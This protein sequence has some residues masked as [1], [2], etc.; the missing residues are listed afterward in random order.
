MT[1]PPVDFGMLG[2][3][4]VLGDFDALTPVVT[5]EQHNTF[6]SNIFSILELVK[7]PSSKSTRNYSNRGN[8]SDDDGTLWAPVL[9][10]SFPV[11][12]TASLGSGKIAASCVL[13]SAPHQ[14]YIGG[15]FRQSFTPKGNTST[16]TTGIPSSGLN[17]IGLY[18]STLKAF[19]PMGKGLDGP[20]RG[21]LC[22]SDTNQVYVVGEFRAPLRTGQTSDAT[23]GNSNQY[24]TLGSFGGGMAIWKSH[25]DQLSTQSSSETVAMTAPGSWEPLPFKGVDGVITSVAK[26]QDGTIYFG[27]NFDTTADG[28][29][30]NAPD[31]QP[32][33][34]DKA[35]VSTGNGLKVDQD[36]NIICD[37]GVRGNWIMR[38]N[39]PGYWRIKFP[40]PIMPTLFRLWNVDV[41]ASQENGGS[42]TS[43]GTK[44]FSIISQP[45]NQVLNLSYIDPDTHAVHYCDVCTLSQRSSDPDY[46]SFQ[47]FLVVKSVSSDAVQINVLSWYGSGGGLGGFD[48][49][50]SEVLVHG[51]DELNYSRC[52]AT[53]DTAQTIAAVSISSP[54]ALGG[55]NSRQVVDNDRDRTAS[56]T[57]VGADWVKMNSTNGWGTFLAA[58]VSTTDKDARQ[59]AYVDLSPYLADSGMYDVYLST[60]ACDSGAVTSTSLSNACADRG[61]V[62]VNMYFTSPEKPTTI[63]L[64]QTRN[65]DTNEK[66]YSGM[67]VRSSANFKPHVVVR[68]SVSKTGTRSGPHNT[69]T[70]VVDSIR[71]VKQT[72]LNDTNGLLFYR[73]STGTKSNKK[74]LANTKDKVQGLDSSVWGNLP[75]VFSSNAVVHSLVAY[76]GP[77][78]SS[79]SESSLLFIGGAFETVGYSNVVAW[80][81]STVVPLRKAIDGTSGLDGAVTSMVVHQSKLYTAGQFQRPRDS[82]SLELLG[83]LAVYDIKA[84]TWSS[85]GNTTQNFK[86]GTRFDSVELSADVNGQPQLIVRGAF[87][88]QNRTTPND[89]I[90]VWDI[91]SK[92][93]VRND[94]PSSPDAQST[95]PG[96]GQFPFGYVHGKVSYLNHVLGSSANGTANMPV[97]LIAGE[98]DSLDTYQVNH[99]KNM[100]WL[101]S[102]GVPKT[103]NLSPAVPLES[104]QSQSSELAGDNV[105]NHTT[106][107]PSQPITLSPMLSKSSAGIVYFNKSSQQWITIVGGTH[108]DGSIST[109]YYYTSTASTSIQDPALTYKDLNLASTIMGEV[110]ALGLNKDEET[111]YGTSTS[112]SDLLLIGGSFKTVKD[113]STVNALALF[114][115]TADQMVS[116]NSMP[117]LKGVQDRD[118]VVQVIKSRPGDSKGTLIVAG[119]FSGV[120]NGIICELICIWDPAAARDALEKGTS[121]EASFKSVYG[122][123]NSKSHVGTLKGVVHDIA[124]E[125][126]N[127]MLVAGD[128]IVNGVHC[129]V[130]GFN[131][132]NSKW[133]T[134]G[135]MVDATDADS[136]GSDTLTGPVTTIAHDSVLHQFFIAGRSLSDGSA[137]FM[138]WNGNHFIQVSTDFQP[139]SDIQ[140][141]EI[142]P[143]TKD[144]PLRTNS[145]PVSDSFDN[146][147]NGYYENP[148]THLAIIRSV[149]SRSDTKSG[150][151]TTTKK[152]L[153]SSSSS[154]SVDV[155]DTTRILEQGFVLMVSGRLVLGSSSSGQ[156]QNTVDR[157]ESSLA[158]FDGQSWFPYLQ[159]SRD[160]SSTSKGTVMATTNVQQQ[161]DIG[162]VL[163]ERADP[164]TTTSLSKR[165]RDQGVFHAL[166]IAHLP[167]IIAREYLALKWVVVISM[168]ISLALIFLIVLF[169]FIYAWIMRRFSKNGRAVRPQWSESMYKDESGYYSH[170]SGIGR[171]SSSEPLGYMDNAT[172]SGSFFGRQK[173]TKGPENTSAVLASLGITGAVLESDRERKHQPN[174]ANKDMD[175]ALATEFVRTHEQQPPGEDTMGES[176]ESNAPPSPD[177]NSKKARYSDPNGQGR[178]S[179]SSDLMN[180]LSQGRRFSSLL[181]AGHDPTSP[182]SPATT[183]TNPGGAL[184]GASPILSPGHPPDSTT[185]VG[186]GVFYYAKYP[187][188]AREIGELGFQA[189][190]RILVVDMSDDIWWM[191][192]IQ[193]A[194]GQQMHGVFPSNYVGLSP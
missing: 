108:E 120:G 167:R 13:N 84:K 131:F 127:N 14:V 96:R 34:L 128:L 82:G 176:K 153:S 65:V 11:D 49:Y 77:V 54:P 170:L 123:S 44:T 32:V 93:W 101:T 133:T 36:R 59:Q 163:V 149:D 51:A 177:R 70:V 156:S 184:G 41:S 8:S 38:D 117:V 31:I 194:N 137:Y 178:D 152:V 169:G 141:L 52:S 161:E 180:P 88:W 189:G 140:R 138:K 71:F 91:G 80:D 20:V 165:I 134:F 27:G 121:L 6:E 2:P 17:F 61:S 62:D 160:S 136:P 168:A 143:A 37:T 146:D 187:F 5:M 98:I 183:M 9:L 28:V 193:D 192:V 81:G 4:A 40:T 147:F 25:R 63:T 85:F 132:D 155:Y 173:T 60:P 46:K 174:S 188:H 122:D 87:A 144:A 3:M 164:T 112:G 103:V 158:F 29:S 97:V 19:L 50:Q 148:G 12:Q 55:T 157:Q 33:N 92:E 129:G 191:G 76:R 35:L 190:E 116:P 100:A 89:S 166:A 142:L 154:G 130:A 86:P 69:Q 16:S 105:S 162:Q 109:G 22:D 67:V 21:L 115:L 53:K 90:A 145:P 171:Q 72:T 179:S 124:F 64:S 181:T 185:T 106:V 111:G 125:D 102:S 23:D 74:G 56:S 1:P 68:P 135:S 39:M 66:I 150:I 7:V 119:D 75:T 139:T 175:H 57:L 47:D 159:S 30:F 48:V 58:S 99:P 182:I 79:S 73:P 45:S 95:K 104:T 186:G 118:P 26:M 42:I 110:L 24:Q 114:D 78:G 15:S 126:D 18:D 107:A 94:L 10:A 151:V 83:G 172:K 113:S 43:H